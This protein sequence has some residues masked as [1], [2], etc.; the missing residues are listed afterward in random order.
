MHNIGSKTV[1]RGKGMNFVSLKTTQ[2]PVFY[3]IPPQIHKT[4]SF[5]VNGHLL[6]PEEAYPGSRN[7]IFHTVIKD[8]LD[9]GPEGIK[10]DRQREIKRGQNSKSPG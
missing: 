7:A 9:E 4:A 1:F 6:L 10:R 5:L 2:N 3:F 8:W